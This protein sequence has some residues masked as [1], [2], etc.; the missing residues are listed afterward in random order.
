MLHVE[1]SK[2]ISAHRV[3]IQEELE[4]IKINYQP[5]LSKQIL[6]TN[7]LIKLQKGK[8]MKQD[9]RKIKE[10]KRKKKMLEIHEA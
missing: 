7:K 4:D 10:K 8:K 3:G 5:F 1:C 6:Q 9:K 2:I